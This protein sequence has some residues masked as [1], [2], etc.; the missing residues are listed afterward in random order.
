MNKYRAM[1]Y[2]LVAG[3]VFLLVAMFLAAFWGFTYPHKIVDEQYE[4]GKSA[5]VAVFMCCLAA[6]CLCGLN[7]QNYYLLVTYAVLQVVVM[8]NQI[9]YLLPFR[10]TRIPN[11]PLTGSVNTQIYITLPPKVMMV[12]FAFSLAYR[13]RRAERRYK[14]A[15]TG[16][17][18][19]EV[20]GVGVGGSCGMGPGSGGGALHHRLPCHIVSREG[21]QQLTSSSRCSSVMG[22]QPS[23]SANQIPANASQPASTA[24]PLLYGA[25]SSLPSQALNPNPNQQSL[26][27]GGIA[28]GPHPPHPLHRLISGPGT[29]PGGQQGQHP[30]P[31]PPPPS[32]GNQIIQTPPIYPLHRPSVTDVGAIMSSPPNYHQQQ[33][34]N[35]GQLQRSMYARHAPGTG[36]LGG[37]MGPSNHYQQSQQNSSYHAYQSSSCG[38]GLNDLSSLLYGETGE[39]ESL[40]RTRSSGLS[41]YHHN[42]PPPPLPPMNMNSGGGGWSSGGG[43]H[44]GNYYY[45]SLVSSSSSPYDPETPTSAAAA[46]KWW[47]PPSSAHLKQQYR[48][49]YRDVYNPNF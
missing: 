4:S 24:P 26:N 45:Q 3:N 7:F 14:L 17:G 12:A 20:E 44:P 25:S 36:S 19:A 21:Q 9:F 31:L 22:A 47:P 11:W 29:T 43:G 30:S 39:A 34:P 10:W 49:Y 28:A 5:Y 38:G 13:L 15:S 6:I 41:S 1:T 46:P 42:Q 40:T 48:P 33:Q 37:N 23:H 2:F 16:A 18:L 27:N 32:A 8:L 35:Q